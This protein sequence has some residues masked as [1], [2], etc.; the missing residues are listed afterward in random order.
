MNPSAVIGVYVVGLLALGVGT[1]VVSRLAEKKESWA[2]WGIAHNVIP[3]I[4]AIWFIG[5][6]L[7]FFFVATTTRGLP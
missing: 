3:L 6:L 4:S 7:V 5:G 2:L 1:V